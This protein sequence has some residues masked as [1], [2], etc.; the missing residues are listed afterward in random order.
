MPASNASRSFWQAPV[1]EVQRSAQRSARLGLVLKLLVTA[2]AFALLFHSIDFKAFLP[3]LRQ[4]TLAPLAMVVA[5]QWLGFA[6]GTVRW[7]LLL[8]AYGAESIPGILPL[9]RVYMV[10]AFYNT[11]LPG[12]VAGDLLRG[13]VSRDAFAEQGTTRAVSIVLL[14]RILGLWGLL[15]LATISMSLWTAFGGTPWVRLV[16]CGVL[17]AL[18][19]GV[20]LLSRSAILAPHLPA[21][22]RR[23]LARL[24]TLVRPRLFAAVLGLAVCSHLLASLCGHV[25]VH[26][27][28][29]HVKL[30]DSLIVMPLAGAAAYFPFTVA[31]AGARDLAMVELYAACDYTREAPLAGS[32]ALLFTSFVSTGVGGLLQL[33][34]PL[35]LAPQRFDAPPA[36]EG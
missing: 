27:A 8:A 7:R 1:R 4:I 36:A 17:I 13:V 24:P 31:G 29:H 9:L 34:W 20:L 18:L 16:A 35:R 21:V 14:D 26:A 23:W 28:S 30:T 33:F 2:G 10:G 6:L 11:Y 22:L 32:L 25:L 12:A 19:L 5:L 15:A 3:A